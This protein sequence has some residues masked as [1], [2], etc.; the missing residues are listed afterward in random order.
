MVRPK[1]RKIAEAAPAA[2]DAGSHA[3]TAPVRKTEASSPAGST[4]GS[5]A[6]VLAQANAGGDSAEREA[7]SGSLASRF[8]QLFGGTPAGGSSVSQVLAG[9]SRAGSADSGTAAGQTQPR[10]G[11]GVT[12]AACGSD[13][14]EATPA[15]RK[16]G[17]EE[18]A[19]A[20]ASKSAEALSVKQ[21]LTEEEQRERDAKTLFVGNVPLKWEKKQLRQALRAAVGDKYSGIFKPIWFRAVPLEDKWNGKMRKAGSILGAYNE[22][23]ADAKNAYVV[24]TSSEDVSVVRHAVNGYKASDRHVLRADGV[25][26]AATLVNF[27]RKRSIFVGNLPS[28]TA[29]AD[30]REVFA[31]V[32]SIDAV[33]VIRDR[34]TKACKG[35]AFIRFSERR[36]VKAALEY[37]GAEVQ[38]RPI[39]VMKVERPP[40]EDDGSTKVDSDHPAAR[41]IAMRNMAR[42]MKAARA[43]TRERDARSGKKPKSKNK[44]KSKAKKAK[45]SKNRKA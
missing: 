13:A 35:F 39:R 4:I 1:R 16:S 20:G 27:D 41:R 40:G 31:S 5:V 14:A 17:T 30:L 28:S 7:S 10:S 42:R 8:S 3:S 43:K 25:G 22:H 12:A 36:S 2:P 9:F 45:S 19:S 44:D 6:S 18:E 29:E 37:W 11:G 38:G 15:K 21:R 26:E 33:R 24:L 34:V 32:G 23:A